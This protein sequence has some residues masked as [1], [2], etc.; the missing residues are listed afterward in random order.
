V[1]KARIESTKLSAPRRVT[2]EKRLEL[3]REAAFLRAEKRDFRD[4]SPVEDW[5]AAEKEIDK[6]LRKRN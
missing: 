1:S 6:G 3:I 2:A 5:L 4:G